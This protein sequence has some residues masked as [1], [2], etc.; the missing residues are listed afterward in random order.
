MFDDLDPV[1]DSKYNIDPSIVNRR[2]IYK[3]VVGSGEGRE[4]SDYQVSNLSFK[5]NRCKSS[6]RPL[7]K[8]LASCQLP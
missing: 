3:D 7:V 4:W 5:E 1:E 8:S 6:N 2:G